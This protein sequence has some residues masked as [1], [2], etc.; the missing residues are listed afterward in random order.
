VFAPLA[1]G[2][3]LIVFAAVALQCVKEE[4]PG[5]SPPAAP[6]P[7]DTPPP[8][9]VT[10]PPEP[11]PTVSREE[12]RIRE[13]ADNVISLSPRPSPSPAASPS[14]A[15]TKETDLFAAFPQA[16]LMPE[17][18]QIG[19]LQDGITSSRDFLLG[20]SRARKFL[21]GITKK[22]VDD[23]L[24]L[25]SVLAEVKAVVSYPLAQGYVPQKYRIGKMVF[26]NDNELRANIRLYKDDAVTEGEIY[27]TKADDA[28]LISDLQA[29]FTLLGR[30]YRKPSEPFVPGGYEFLL[31]K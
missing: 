12:R 24:I 20:L 2:I 31:D 4:P 30:P 8:A 18:F 17:D 10:P 28:W 15:L 23:A 3:V 7:V 21:E 6:A 16:R 29:G 27:L 19:P 11:A 22:K 25:P 1:G 14:A 9:A 13:A 5:T 26:E